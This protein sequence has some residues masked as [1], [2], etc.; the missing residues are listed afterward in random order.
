MI[1]TRTPGARR[2]HFAGGILIGL[3]LATVCFAVLTRSETGNGKG[4]A[5]SGTTTL[6]LAHGLDPA[7]PVHLAMTRMAQ[8]LAELSGS[9][10]GIDIY[11]SG[12]LGSET[13]CI[14]QLQNGQLA[15]TK[16]SWFLHP[17][18]IC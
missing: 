12:Q 10:M 13:E 14:E 6:K 8:R 18:G 1:P 2:S 7:H 11:P 17:G 15:M 9:T 5:A 3:L 4:G 16:T